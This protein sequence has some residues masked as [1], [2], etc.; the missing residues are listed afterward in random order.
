M[1]V[2]ALVHD[3]ELKV[4]KHAGIMEARKN[5]LDF[6]QSK[7]RTKAREA[8][9][10]R[11]AR[12]M[13]QK[14]AQRTQAQLEYNVTELVSLALD[15][16]LGADSPHFKLHFIQKRGKTEVEIKFEDHGKVLDPMSED[17]GGACD[18][19]AFGLRISLW[20]LTN[21]KRKVF[22]LDE[23][24]KGLSS[25]LQPKMFQLLKLLSERLGIQFIIVSA[26]GSDMSAEADKVFEVTKRLGVSYVKEVSV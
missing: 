22:I 4:E 7:E 24:F 21:P 16:I 19:A 25:D 13:I 1:S 26:H 3:L 20:T 2:Q 17:G 23:P 8:H 12:R 6:L 11:I 5:A 9:R 14:A 10:C 15:S 18:I